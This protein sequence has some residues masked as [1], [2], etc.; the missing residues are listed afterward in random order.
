MG[1]RMTT[2]AKGI[3]AAFVLGCVVP[4]VVGAQTIVSDDFNRYNL[5]PQVG[6]MFMDPLGGGSVTLV[7]T[8]TQDA[9]LAISVPGGA[10]HQPYPP[11]NT[12]VRVM[13]ISPNT[14]FTIQ[15]KFLSAASQV[16]QIQGI[17]I[18]GTEGNG[19]R[20]DFSSFGTHT[21]LYAYTTTDGFTSTDSL[22]NRLG[23]TIGANS[24]SPVQMKVQRSGDTWTVSDSV[25]SVGWTSHASFTFPMVVT[26]TGV[27]AGNA[28]FTP[29]TEPAYTALVD[30]FMNVNA[31]IT[32][33]SIT[34]VIDNVK[35]LVYAHTNIPSL[36]SFQV[37]WKT[38]EKAKGLIQYGTTTAYGSSV[39]H[40]DRLTV[41][42]LNVT[43]LP[44]ET[45]YHYRIISEDSTGNKD[46]TADYSTATLAPPNPIVTIWN[47]YSQT[48][49]RIG[50]AQKWVNVLGNVRD[51]H[52]IDS[53]Y[54]TLNGGPKVMLSRGPDT[55]RLLNDGDFNI[56]IPYDQLVNSP[57]TNTIQLMARDFIGETTKT[58][59]TLK[60]S[61]GTVKPLPYTVAWSSS[62]SMYDSAQ[63]VDGVWTASSGAVTPVARGYDRL[64]AVGD[65]SFGDYEATVPITVSGYD[66]T[67]GV[68]GNPSYGPAVGFFIRWI[69]H[70]DNPISGLQPKS[71]YLPL[72]AISWLHWTSVGVSRWELM[73]NNLAMKA[74]SATPTVTF[75]TTYFFKV[76][77]HTIPLQGGFYRFKVWKSG[78]PEPPTWLLTGQET[79]ADPQTGALVLAA[80]HVSA[81]FGPVT[82][83]PVPPDVIPPVISNVQTVF[84]STAAYLTWNTDEPATRTIYYGTT[85]SYGDSVVGKDQIS[86][87][88]ALALRGLIAGTT[89]HYKITSTDDAGNKGTTADATFATN[90][91]ATPTT[92]V[93]DE[94]N[95]SILNTGVWTFVNPTPP[96]NA[97]QKIAG[98]TAV[99]LRAFAGVAHDN[100][101]PSG[102]NAPRLMQNANNTDFDIK[103]KFV[104]TITAS[105][106]A[107]GIVVEQDSLN[108]LRFD[109]IA[110]NPGTQV[111]AASTSNGFTNQTGTTVHVNRALGAFGVGPLI[112]RLQKDA[113]LWMGFYSINGGAT[114]D[115]LGVFV[116][117]MN[118][119][120]V[121]LFVGN[122]ASGG[123]TPEHSAIVDYFRA[124]NSNAQ[125][126]PTVYAASGWNMISIPSAPS[127]SAT[128]TL[129]PG[130]TSR[131]FSFTTQYDE[132]QYLS[133]G[134]GYWLKFAAQDTFIICGTQVSQRNI[135]VRTGWNM[136]GMYE[137]N[138]ATA[139][140]TSTPSSI[141][142]SQFFGFNGAYE[143]NTTLITGRAYW[144]KV[145]QNG[146]LNM[147]G[148]AG[149]PD[150]PIADRA[151]SWA[152]IEVTDAT[153]QH[154]RLYLSGR[155]HLPQFADQPPHPPSGILDVR[156]AGDR[157]IEG[158]GTNH[159]IL[160]SSA[161]Y[162]VTVRASNLNGL[163][164]TIAD[165]SGGTLFSSPLKEGAAVIIPRDLGSLVLNDN[166]QL[167]TEFGLSQNYPN[168]FN[169]ST[170]IEYA[171][172]M[173]THV[174]LEV[175]D[176]IG[177]KV[178]T[179]VNDMRP[180][181]YHTESFS[182]MP[183]ASGLYFYRLSTSETTMLKK[184]ILIK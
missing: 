169:P 108:V 116:H 158:I 56:D 33:D 78:D 112:L 39:S 167:P 163:S 103:V 14:D 161:A 30:F 121:G 115:T 62:N 40:T 32:D 151:Q 142:I 21:A 155:E 109:F 162:P 74:T 22:V 18:E 118:V 26:G 166:I 146:T 130:A 144:V 90:P 150:I 160:I 180:A 70:S 148:G 113:S 135:A 5:V 88:H 13:Q 53:L 184:M 71:G 122:S 119:S 77:V 48:F 4:T 58:T 31:P 11:S 72:G 86:T 159:E 131:A 128:T 157:Y 73:G 126:C 95:A 173:A 152:V 51:A 168:P 61:S 41:H 67:S 105:Y 1:K 124:A 138:I 183:L 141:I 76:Q 36:T 120:K 82:I 60:D 101:P 44:K 97:E 102:Y 19:I 24:L 165:A 17:L 66:S 111:F 149:K 23:T 132:K 3:I 134:I 117:P 50:V 140:I 94:F 42:S 12:A 174:T 63:V 182:G 7:N 87:S 79:L 84:G 25:P 93:T 177:Q 28:G 147:S 65:T 49:G 16:F 38:D 123:V 10:M 96:G 8:G 129:F 59:I 107:Q 176:V 47:G 29:G 164:L 171:L 85:A 104:S 133:P 81:S 69:G 178:A 92:L 127:D 139:S 9:A 99:V 100:Y 106:Q 181:G 114:W 55:R 20:I 6:W 75:N 64:I 175:F 35:P 98:D 45:L 2:L 154:G 83:T 80:H 91:P 145:S 46:T 89:Y 57:A 137:T 179:L 34:T 156:Y 15:T 52:G 27:W 172:P 110:S 136:I 37:N 54:Y 153:G 170:T 43:G 125:I 68:F 143:A